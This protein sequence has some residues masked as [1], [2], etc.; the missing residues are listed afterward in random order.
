MGKTVAA[1]PERTAYEGHEGYEPVGGDEVDLSHVSSGPEPFQVPGAEASP[2]AAP[3]S[4]RRGMLSQML[5]IVLSVWCTRVP[6][7][8]TVHAPPHAPARLEH[9]RDAAR[10]HLRRSFIEDP[11]E[12]GRQIV[13]GCATVGK[14]LQKGETQVACRPHGHHFFV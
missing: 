1:L 11:K 8:R 3:S 4:R 2:Y 5:H 6:T 14:Q 12:W 13:L 7:W 9:T 10:K